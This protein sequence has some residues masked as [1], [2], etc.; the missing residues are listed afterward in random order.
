M[1][2]TIVWYAY[3]LFRDWDFGGGADYRVW[4][5]GV[6]FYGSSGHADAD[7]CDD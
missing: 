5:P 3:S 7:E 1:G 4:V 2:M 6:Y